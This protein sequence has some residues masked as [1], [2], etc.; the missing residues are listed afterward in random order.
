MVKSLSNTHILDFEH[1]N[2]PLEENLEYLTIL[3]WEEYLN[4]QV[5]RYSRVSGH[6]LKNQT[7]P[8]A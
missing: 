1:F 3:V 8:K 7:A 4:T 6:I 5:L 2:P